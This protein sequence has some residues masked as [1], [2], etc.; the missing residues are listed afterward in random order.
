MKGTQ[1]LLATVMAVFLASVPGRAKPDGLGIVVQADHASMDTQAVFEGTTVFDGDRLSTGAGGMLRLGIGE[2]ILDLTANSSVV[3]HSNTGKTTKA[4]ELELISG[5]V[6]LSETAESRAEIVA[7][8]ARVRPVAETR[9]VVQAEFVGPR[10]LI[11]C[12]RR[13]PTQ[14]FF[15]GES[16]TVAEGRCYRVLMN[17]SAEGAAGDQSGKKPGKRGKALVLIAVGAAV[18]VGIIIWRETRGAESPDRP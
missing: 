11:V 2:T 13:G 17:A 16:A 7:S 15:Q 9:G 14:I 18:A 3:V 10:E 12:A 1:R 6:V 4:L 5:T 8:S